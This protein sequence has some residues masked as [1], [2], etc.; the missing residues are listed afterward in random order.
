MAPVFTD[1]ELKKLLGHKKIECLHPCHEQGT[2]PCCDFYTWKCWFCD[3]CK[4]CCLWAEKQREKIECIKE[5][6]MDAKKLGAMD[7]K[8]DPRPWCLNCSS[9]VEKPTLKRKAADSEGGVCKK[10]DTKKV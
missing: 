10:L 1:T 4:Y 8:L 5:D 7:S 9:L 2:C 3:Y 6:K